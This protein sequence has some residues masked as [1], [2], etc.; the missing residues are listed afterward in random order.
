MK[1]LF[2]II[3]RKRNLRRVLAVAFILTLFIEIGSHAF[4]DSEDF[5]H[6]QT[7]GF[8][9]INHAP[10]LAVDTPAKQKQRGPSSNLLDEMMIHSVMLNDLT[11]PSCGISYWTSDYV[12]SV[13]R[14]L[15]GITDPPFHPP[16]L[17]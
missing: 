16:K 10:P 5:A 11:S 1:R 13:T 6:F 17:V 15:S 7:L 14:P 8:C 3:K 9:G 2:R 4:S 12:K